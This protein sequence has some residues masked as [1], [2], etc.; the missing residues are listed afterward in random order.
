MQNRRFLL[1]LLSIFQPLGVVVCSGIAYGFI[2]KYSCATDLKSCKS[3]TLTPGEAC[4]SKSDN[5]G[6]RY[7]MF[8]LGGIAL[9]IFLLRFVLFTFQESPK[10]LIGRGRDEDAMKVLHNV[11]KVN[12]YDCRLSMDDFRALEANHGSGSGLPDSPNGSGDAMLKDSVP[13][14]SAEV[15]NPPFMQQVKNEFARIKILFSTSALTRLTILVWIIYA[16]DYWAFS[17]AGMAFLPISLCC[18]NSRTCH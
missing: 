3:S 7:L 5:M 12:G 1:A 4:C 18:Q 8:T 14:Q 13:T 17:V 11:A 16:F 2:P 10:Y 9:F 6:W 15:A